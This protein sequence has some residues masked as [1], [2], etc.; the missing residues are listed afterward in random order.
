MKKSVII[1]VMATLISMVL[2]SCSTTQECPAYADANVN[3]EE[4]ANV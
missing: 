2:S 3:V 4:V 1:L